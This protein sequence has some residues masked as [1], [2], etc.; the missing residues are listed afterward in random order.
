M[1]T[2]YYLENRYQ[3]S[4]WI[5]MGLGRLKD[6]REALEKACE[7]SRDSM[8]NGMVRVIRSHGEHDWSRQYT[9]L[10][11]FSAGYTGTVEEALKEHEKVGERKE[12]AKE[13]TTLKKA[14]RWSRFL[15]VCRYL[16]EI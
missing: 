3:D 1:S 11:T 7:L 10:C 2:Y 6:G 16:Y 8:M 5:K 14:K 15:R 4:S 12:Q 9:T 13:L